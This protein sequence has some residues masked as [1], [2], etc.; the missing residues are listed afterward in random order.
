MPASKQDPVSNLALGGFRADPLEDKAN[1][2]TADELWPR[3]PPFLSFGKF[4]RDSTEPQ[5]IKSEVIDQDII[6][7]D[8]EGPSVAGKRD[9]TTGTDPRADVEESASADDRA[10]RLARFTALN[11]EYV[12]LRNGK[13][14]S[15]V[16]QSSLEG[17]TVQTPRNSP[18]TIERRPVKRQRFFIELPTVESVYG[19]TKLRHGADTPSV[20]E[21]NEKMEKMKNPKVKKLKGFGL[22]LD[23]VRDRLLAVGLDPYPITLEKE[24]QD[25]MVKRRFIS[26]LYGGDTQST[27][28]HIGKHFL[29]AHGLD[30]F[31]Y[32]NLDLNPHAP[33]MPGSPGLFF[34]A[35]GEDAT[36][37]NDGHGPEVPMRV[38]TRIRPGIWQYQGQYVLSP[39]QSL[40]RE[41]WAVQSSK[42]HHTWAKQI[43]KKDWGRIV[44]CRVFL[45]K[46]YGRQ[47]T[48]EEVEE[49]IQDTTNSYKYGINEKDIIQALLR[50]DEFIAVWTMKCVGYDVNFQRN[51]A[52]KYPTWVPPPSK[53][54]KGQRR[55]GKGIAVVLKQEVRP[56]SDSSE[57]EGDDYDDESENGYEDMKRKKVPQKPN[58]ISEKAQQV[59][60]R[61]HD[62]IELDN[63]EEELVYKSRGTRSRPVLV[64]D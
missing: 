33:E 8:H 54:K 62:V 15:D 38:I 4:K 24:I 43:M 34:G 9:V 27:L 49:A 31:M 37:W 26:S 60:K 36:T 52:E 35:N 20:K 16:G 2:E 42:V 64:W 1:I 45:R 46:R 57:E 19:K 23:T 13:V 12:G 7:P 41:E 39:A 14:N 17:D 56:D 11:R 58:T 32:P 6:L 10:E 5:T 40:T 59:G 28:P 3:S 21:L 48:E 47:V 30:D 55:G 51:L 25:V 44:R 63:E 18:A 61:K 50:G 22:S 29:D 53:P